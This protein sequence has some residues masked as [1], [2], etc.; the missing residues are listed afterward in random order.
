M[1]VSNKMVAAPSLG[2]PPVKSGSVTTPIPCAAVRATMPSPVAASLRTVPAV[3]HVAPATRTPAPVRQEEKA[4]AFALARPHTAN[5]IGHKE[6]SCGQGNRPEHPGR[7]PS[8][9]GPHPPVV[10]GS[11]PSVR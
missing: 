9:A 6:L 1:R 2:R 3:G 8:L 7:R 11:Q 5:L 10:P 4:A